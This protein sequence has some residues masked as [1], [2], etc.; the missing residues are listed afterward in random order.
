[1]I[2]S[3]SACSRKINVCNKLIN[4]VKLIKKKE[5]LLRSEAFLKH[6]KFFV[7]LISSVVSMFS[8]TGVSCDHLSAAVA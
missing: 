4:A 1:M 2:E 3:S 8:F 7:A 6:Y 5:K